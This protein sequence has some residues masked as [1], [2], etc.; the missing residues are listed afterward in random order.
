MCHRE[1]E[2]T[3]KRVFDTEIRG[4][5]EQPRRGHFAAEQ[6]VLRFTNHSQTREF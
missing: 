2:K 1:K 3:L 6:L 5:R 4:N